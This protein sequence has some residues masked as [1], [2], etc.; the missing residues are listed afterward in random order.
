MV[1]GTN[2]YINANGY[3]DPYQKSLPSGYGFK[4]ERDYLSAIPTNEL[5]LNK[6]YVQ[7]PGW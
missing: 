2:V 3:I 5:T 7:N 6:N 1:V 4:P